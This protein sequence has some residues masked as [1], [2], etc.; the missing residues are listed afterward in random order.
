MAAIARLA[1]RLL[2]Q[3]QLEIRELIA[4]GWTGTEK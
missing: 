4:D 3:C 1:E 2:A